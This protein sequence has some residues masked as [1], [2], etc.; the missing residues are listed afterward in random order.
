MRQLDLF[1]AL[2]SSTEGIDTEFKS[3]RGGM[4]GSFWESYS[5]M[6]NTQG[7]T[8]V[9]GVAEKSTGLVWEGVPDAAQLRTVLWGQ[10]NDRHKV[11]TNLLRDDDVRTVEDEGR[12]FVVVNV[13]R[14]SR[15]QRPVFVGPN[16]MTGTYRRA[17]EGD[18]RC[19]DDEVRRMLADQSDTPADSQIVEHFGQ[20]DFDPET[21]KQYR[22]RFAS[23]APDHPW[24][25]LDDAPL[26]TKLSALRRDR[27][28]GLEGATVAGL[29]MFGRFEA[30][31]DALPGFH[32][33]YRER[34]SDDPAVRWT[35]RVVP[36]GTWENNLFQFY[37]RVMQ[38]LSGDLKM[39]FQLDRELYRKDDSAVHEALREAVVNALV[40]ADH[41]GQGGVVIER[42]PDR[43]ELSNPG[44]LLVSRV[45]LLQGG[46]SECRN[47]S[48][49]L[50]FQLMGGGDKAGSGMDKIRAGWRAQHWRSPRLE[51]SLQPDRVKLVLPMVS[52]IPDEVDQA[53]RVRFGERFAK[54]DKTAVQAVVT[55]QVEGSV[56]NSRM[57]E[58]TGEHSKDI[59]GVLQ[60]LVRDGLLTQQ[61]QRRWASYRV[62]EDS[63][64]SGDDSPHLE[65]DSPQSSPQL[66][67]GSPQ[68]PPNSP[69]LDRLA[70]LSPEIQGL[71]PIA[72]PARK[73]KKLPVDQLKG[74]IQQLC[75]G[76]WLATSE[77]ATLVDRDAEKLQSRFLTAMVREG[78][79]ELRYPDVRNRPD[80]AYRTVGLSNK[81]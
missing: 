81:G 45:Q 59:T 68:L 76:R 28:T 48:L 51:E 57:Q 67:G 18:Y 79:L 10:L 43:I 64:Q 58:I 41:R 77:I 33:D 23:R 62:A 5:A 71:L 32:V 65:A 61:N 35:D 38:R 72:G 47:K 69:Q 31:R 24:L 60:S 75:D 11:S 21:V 15:L 34:L 13:P 1:S 37:L 39:P 46:V 63:P 56:T 19:S 52:L 80:Q 30:L 16:P 36:D 50:M 40:H 22:N 42:Y 20:P 74:L 2:Q 9:L 7:G 44:S 55:A 4:P 14:A 3:A 53:L 66:G 6:A 12:Q 49:Q 78:V 17:D 70:G 54:L 27:A 8:I 26:L 25:L 73:N 29:L